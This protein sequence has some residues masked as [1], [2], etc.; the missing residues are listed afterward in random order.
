[1]SE[2]QC[3]NVTLTTARLGQ[4]S[5]LPRVCTLKSSSTYMIKLYTPVACYA[6]DGGWTAIEVW[7]AVL[8]VCNC[9]WQFVPVLYS[10]RE[11]DILYAVTLVYGTKSL[12]DPRV[13]DDGF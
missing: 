6:V 1:M 8:N 5:H 9:G 11:N 2:I 13:P 12:C 4:D 7:T 10:P 3:W